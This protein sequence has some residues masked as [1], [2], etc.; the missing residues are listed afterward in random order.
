[1]GD[2]VDEFEG[3]VVEEGESGVCAWDTAYVSPGDFALV[4]PAGGVGVDEEDVPG[5]N[6]SEELAEEEKQE[7]K[8]KKK[9]KTK[10]KGK[11]R[12]KKKTYQPLHIC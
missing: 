1:M 8:R 5:E 7:K 10:T 2:F 6:K 12:K 3:F 9:E 4:F 11:E